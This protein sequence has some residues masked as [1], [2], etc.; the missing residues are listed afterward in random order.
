MQMVNYRVA[1]NYYVVDRCSAKATMVS[2]I[3]REQDRVTISAT[4][5]TR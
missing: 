1:G 2:G 4:D 3:G 5:Q